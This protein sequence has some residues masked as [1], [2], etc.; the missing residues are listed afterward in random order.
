MFNSIQD[1]PAAV[2]KKLPD[3]ACELYMNAYS[4]LQE[5]ATANGE[6]DVVKAT[7]EAHEGAMASLRSEFDV[8]EQGNWYR[9]AVENDL[10]QAGAAADDEAAKDTLESSRISTG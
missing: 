9:A 7:K 5:K 1:L 4:R 3:S 6:T 10:E 8:D 2:R